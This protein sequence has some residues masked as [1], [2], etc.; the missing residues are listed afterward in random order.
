[1]RMTR[2]LPALL[3]L[4]L[5]ALPPACG[6]STRRLIDLPAARTIAV[7]TF[8]NTGYRRDM[9]L[10][11]TQ[12]VLA[13]LRART[14]FAIGSPESADL[15]ISGAMSASESVI[16]L[17]ENDQP[18]QKRLAGQLDVRVTDRRSGQVVKSYVARAQTEYTPD[19]F[20]ESLDGSATDEWARRLAERV[21]QGL[22]TGF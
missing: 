22:E 1:M 14:S 3:L 9:E 7:S 6:Y 10:R 12:A 4:S 17:D 18:I 11:L 21:V 16:T 20:G 8:T 2:L 19:R 15:V 5:A 13:A